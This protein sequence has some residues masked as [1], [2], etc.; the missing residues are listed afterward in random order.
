MRS[1]PGRAHPPLP[2][3]C[4]LARPR[5][6]RKT[7]RRHKSSQR[8]TVSYGPSHVALNC[9]IGG[10]IIGFQKAG[11]INQGHWDSCRLCSTICSTISLGVAVCA[12]V[13]DTVHLDNL[14]AGRDPDVVTVSWPADHHLPSQKPLERRERRPSIGLQLLKNAFNLNPLVIIIRQSVHNNAQN[15]PPINDNIKRLLRNNG[16]T[17]EVRLLDSNHL[18]GIPTRRLRRFIVASRVGKNMLSD[19]E[20][21]LKKIKTYY[22]T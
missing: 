14:A 17:T 20:N 6:P 3:S 2:S 11:F 1:P 15:K 18:A 9:G 21:S 8:K 12:P 4:K 7:N 16:Y 19:L 10:D 13:T 5:P 22:N